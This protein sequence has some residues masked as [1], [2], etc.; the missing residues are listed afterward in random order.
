MLPWFPTAAL[1]TLSILALA[2]SKA[3]ATFENPFVLD[4]SNLG[5]G[6]TGPF[7]QVTINVDST[8]TVAT[9]TFDAL[10]NGG[11]TY[12]FHSQGAVAVNVNATS[13]TLGNLT[14]T[15]PNKNTPSLSDGG[16][17]Q[18]DGYGNFNQTITDFDG[19]NY[20]ASEI[21]FTLTRTDGGTWLA[22]G[23]NVLKLTSGTTPAIAAAQIGAS[24]GTKFVTTG[25]AGGNGTVGPPNTG[26]AG[27]S[28]PPSAVLLGLGGLGV[29]A[30]VFRS[31]RRQVAMA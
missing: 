30:V 29:A 4:T 16:S 6:F 15:G 3:S 17:G 10:T 5:S 11:Y 27:A 14:G 9:I 25:Y 22:D 12:L 21:Q 20:A 23:S 24:D 8:G 7:A 28:P 1:L 13:W 18:E 19:Y 26:G 31:R 2:P